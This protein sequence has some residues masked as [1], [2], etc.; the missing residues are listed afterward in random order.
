M[1]RRF[2]VKNEKN[3]GNFVHVI[4]KEGDKFNRAYITRAMYENAFK[5]AGYVL[6][7]ENLPDNITKD[8]THITKDY[9][10]DKK[11]I[12]FLAKPVDKMNVT[13]PR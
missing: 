12:E 1:V 13:E 5:D 3:K 8:I 6:V 7:N 11:V 10:E 9:P 4:K 2:G